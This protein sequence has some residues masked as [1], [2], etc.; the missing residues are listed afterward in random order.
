MDVRKTILKVFLTKYLL[1]IPLFF[2][3]PPSSP[4]AS[5]FNLPSLISFLLPSLILPPSIPH[6]MRKH[7]EQYTDMTAL[8]VCVE[9]LV[10]LSV[11]PSVTNRQACLA[12]Y[13]VLIRLCWIESIVDLGQASLVFL[14]APMIRQSYGDS[15]DEVMMVK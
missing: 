9:N 11:S 12:L 6:S 1:P 13:I 7:K 15:P 10:S 8:H 3:L 2:L 14:E 5:S 4:V